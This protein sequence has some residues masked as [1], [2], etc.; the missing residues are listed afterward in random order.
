MKRILIHTIPAIISF[1]WLLSVNHTINPFSL[2]GP[3]F[4]RFYLILIFMFYSLILIFKYFK[5]K[6][7]ETVLYGL[8]SIILVGIIKLFIGIILGKPVGFLII[9][10]ILELIVLMI[11]RRSYL[12]M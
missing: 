1:I 6:I 11:I 2:K 4:L 10:L 5:H 7:S 12:N 3:D 9:I 8:V